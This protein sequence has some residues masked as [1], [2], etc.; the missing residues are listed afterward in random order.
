MRVRGFVLEFRKV[1]SRVSANVRVRRCSM[2]A[3][4]S[5]AP[6][7]AIGLICNYPNASVSVAGVTPAELDLRSLIGVFVGSGVSLVLLICFVLVIK[8]RCLSSSN[9]AKKTEMGKQS[10]NSMDSVEKDPDIIPHSEGT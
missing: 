2:E 10:S 8:L 1:F 7:S 9:K 3:S 4:T 5:Y 6:W